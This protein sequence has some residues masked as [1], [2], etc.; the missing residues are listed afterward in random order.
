MVSRDPG[1]HGK[2]G[3]R[4]DTSH[5][6]KRP[7]PTA[8]NR[9]AQTPQPMPWERAPVQRGFQRQNEWRPGDWQPGHKQPGADAKGHQGGWQPGDALGRPFMP[10]H[11]SNRDNDKA[12]DTDAPAQSGA[13]RRAGW[14]PGGSRN[15]GGMTRGINPAHRGANKRQKYQTSEYSNEQLS[16]DNPAWQSRNLNPKR[17][18]R[19]RESRPALEHLQRRGSPLW[20]TWERLSALARDLQT[21]LPNIAL[22][23][24]KLEQQTLVVTAASSAM[25]AR[26]RQYEPRLLSGLQARGWLVTRIRFKPTTLHQRREPPRP[27]KAPVPPRAI[28]SMAA[29]AESPDISPELREA[30]QAFVARQR[31]YWGI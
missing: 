26:L 5:L 1:S 18:D 9:V 25:A 7:A 20:D 31:G 3:K 10:E 22:H 28:E 27:E 2:T 12:S 17:K 14:Q 24:L 21:I 16:H 8:G 15:K 30:L 29:L 19:D 13:S 6:D 4:P 11:G 23:P